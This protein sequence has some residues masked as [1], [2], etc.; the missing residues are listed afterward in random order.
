MK[1]SLLKLYLLSFCLLLF[2]FAVQAQNFHFIYI[3]P[4]NKTPF[5][6]KID[7]QTI[8]SSSS[9]YII[10]PRLTQDSYKIYI[11]FP[12]SKLSELT[13]TFVLNDKDAGYVL[14][15]D[16]DETWYII[17]LLSKKTLPIE[18][19]LQSGKDVVTMID[20]DEFARVLSEVVNDSSIRKIKSPVS[21]PVK[22]PVEVMPDIGKDT[23]TI[24]K[25]VKASTN[26]NCKVVATKAVFLKLLKKMQEQK[27]DI[28]KHAVAAKGFIS[29]CFTTGQIKEL[30]LLFI[31][32]GERYKFYVA[33]FQHISDAEN[34]V[35]L[36]NQF[37]DN[38]YRSRFKAMF[39]H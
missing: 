29:S 13:V 22:T 27:K 39:N 37:T 1:G 17:D 38:Y 7:G 18:R 34:F 16:V 14:K 24:S 19:Q 28:D 32:D 4:E 6:I 15:K 25:T 36:E 31:T 23:I 10:I 26:K 21:K 8:P 20:G 35:V 2:S 5:Y 9:G 30:G 12:Q 33:A 11:G 3:Q